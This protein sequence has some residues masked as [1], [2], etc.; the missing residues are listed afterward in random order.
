MAMTKK[1][2]EAMEGALIQCALRSTSEVHPDVPAPNGSGRAKGWMVRGSD[3][4]YGWSEC[5]RHG[6]DG[7][8][9]ASQGSKELY[10]TR[11]LA[12]RAVRYKMEQEFARQLRQI[13]KKINEAMKALPPKTDVTGPAPKEDVK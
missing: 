1:E 11:I 13:D 12:L 10:S 7:S 3:A 4:V 5:F 9:C 8:G 6:S 2:K